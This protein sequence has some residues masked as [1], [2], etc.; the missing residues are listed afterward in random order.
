MIKK[1]TIITILFALVALTAFG[2]T[3]NLANTYWRNE[4]T[5]DWL[6]GFAEE[7][8]I[9][10]NRVLEIACQVE[11][12]DAYTLTADNGEI[13]KVSKMKNGRRMITIGNAKPTVC[14]QITTA[15]LP[16]YPTKDLT[17][18]KDNGYQMGD[19]VTVVGWLKDCPKELLDKNPEFDIIAYSTFFNH[20]EIK[21]CGEI[22]YHGRFVVKMPVENTQQV[23]MDWQRTAVRTVLE[24]G[25][26]YFFLHD[27]KT[28]Q[29]LM[30]GS[31]ARVQNEL[32]TY[33]IRAN[34]VEYSLKEGMTMEQAVDYKNC[35][36]DM[37]ERNNTRLDSVL[38]NHPTLSRRY[39]DYQ[40]MDNL[41]VMGEHLLR[42]SFYTKNAALPAEV[43]DYVDSHV[44]Q[45][46][47]EPYTLNR[48]F[49]TFLN[50]YYVSASQPIQ[51]ALEMSPSTILRSW[52]KDGIIR[53]SA[54]EHALVDTLELFFADYQAGAAFDDVN[55]KYKGVTERIQKLLQRE[56]IMAA[57]DR[58]YA[59]MPL[60]MQ[61]IDALFANPLLRDIIKARVLTLQIDGARTPLA[62]EQKALIDKIQTSTIR[63][64][65]LALNDHYRDLQQR[66]ISK[67]KSLKANDDVADMSDGE[68]ILRKITEPYRGRLILL[69]IWGTWCAP[70]KEAM[71]HS[72]EEFERLKDYNIVYLYLANNSSDAA[73]KNV[74][75][76]YDLT[77]DNIVHYNLPADQQR[78]VEQFLNV[79]AFP[80]YRIIDRDG[81]VL[82]VDADPRKLEAL[83]ALLEKLK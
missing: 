51:R 81:N 24:P 34:S 22:D 47:R 50:L 54:E 80:F 21:A 72:K 76:E 10:N 61:V 57:M 26:T 6:I 71:A 11:K 28:G 27:Y 33:G 53:L 15:T 3:S 17:P 31:N 2:Q 42:A 56:D 32:L 40:H 64:R 7:H 78:A 29:Q 73:W 30:M 67:A 58:F 79:Q 25:E 38:T 52:E 5:G 18:F 63:Q 83:A 8:L 1:Q 37:H 65:V 77:G 14:S 44:W 75:K 74:I 13:I 35:W 16:D 12:K 20:K 70:C 59:P 69:D 4:A 55:K 68:K 19:T 48:D 36:A 46:L 60:E 41:G 66:D 82:D 62:D 49:N 39:A 23:Y 45:N 43:I 9:Y